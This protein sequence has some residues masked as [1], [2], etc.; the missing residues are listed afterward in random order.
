MAILSSELPL[1]AFGFGQNR[2]T[3]LKDQ[4]AET[5]MG[6]TN[7]EEDAAE[8]LLRTELLKVQS[9]EA[10]LGAARVRVKLAEIS[11][12]RT[13]KR[14]NQ[15]TAP[16]QDGSWDS[17]AASSS[18][19]APAAKKAK[20][21][22]TPPTPDGD[23]AGEERLSTLRDQE[24]C[25]REEVES[26]RSLLRELE[27]ELDRELERQAQD[28]SPLHAD[29]SCT[30]VGLGALPD[31]PLLEVLSYLSPR[32][33]L[34]CRRVCRRWRDLALHPTIWREK[35]LTVSRKSIQLVV[36]ALR[37][38]PC[39]GTLCMNSPELLDR[40]LSEPVTS[41]N[42]GIAALTFD[43]RASDT[44]LLGLLLRRQASLGRLKT[45]EI[46]L[47]IDEYDFE[48]SDYCRLN[49]LLAQLCYSEGLESINLKVRCI[50]S[51]KPLP[52]LNSPEFG[53]PVSATLRELV[54]STRCC[55]VFLNPYLPLHLGW[56]A[57]TLEVVSLNHVMPHPSAALQLSAMPR[58]R[59]LTC[60][61]LENM[62]ALL[63]CPAL[64]SLRLIATAGD[65]IKD[66]VEPYLPGVREYLRLAATRLE[67]VVLEFLDH[68]DDWYA[69][70]GCTQ[71]S[72]LVLSLA[73]S[74]GV[75]PALRSLKFVYYDTQHDWEVWPSVP[76]PQLPHLAAILHRLQNLTSLDL[77][78]P[79]SEEVLSALDAAV[80]P[81][82]QLLKAFFPGCPHEWVHCKEL[83]A[84][85]LLHPG[86]HITMECDD[87]SKQSCDFCKKH[88]CHNFAV[89]Y[90]LTLFS[91]AATE[92]CGVEHL[93]RAIF[94][95]ADS[96]C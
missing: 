68:T 66:S 58:L 25:A 78:G 51:N 29:E 59:E 39:L 65:P 38:A 63:Q 23:A 60:P 56:H 57:T 55:D 24:R 50:G 16:Q 17:P 96:S 22:L 80:L 2:T 89:K 76:V 36:S 47:G 77:G 28:D 11:R 20:V 49:Q 41:I 4:V 45:V 74:K 34:Q 46:E 27:R 8:V 35:C 14:R 10:A 81:D 90:E 93:K 84:F 72:D 42:C 9:A 43:G 7:P 82:L 33:L 85:M 31:D 94:I 87:H 79:L 13:L 53:A 37:L 83:R 21:A 73:G 5:T 30:Q 92:P 15:T 44:V 69:D 62:P 86:L 6:P 88:T 32:Q 64:T 12:D 95:S 48:D 1:T 67:H 18:T 61:L 70:A 75:V 71:T 3:C 26:A 40:L 91:H 54:L 52:V 19:S